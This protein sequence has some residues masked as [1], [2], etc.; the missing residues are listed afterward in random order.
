MD[1]FKIKYCPKCERDCEEDEEESVFCSKCGTKI[2]NRCAEIDFYVEIEGH[3]SRCIALAELFDIA[4][5]RGLT[6]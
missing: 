5:E 2:S 6:K 4:R 3:G 1:E